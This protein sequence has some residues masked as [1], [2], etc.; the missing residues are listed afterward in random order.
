MTEN[1]YPTHQKFWKTNKIVSVTTRAEIPLAI[2][3]LLKIPI[4]VSILPQAQSIIK[5]KLNFISLGG[6]RTDQ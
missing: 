2:T 6:E 5:M 4:Y 1:L 3:K